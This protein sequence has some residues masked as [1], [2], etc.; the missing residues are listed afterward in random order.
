[1]VEWDWALRRASD[2]KWHGLLQESRSVHTCMWWMYNW[3]TD[4]GELEEGEWSSM[5][6]KSPMK[7]FSPVFLISGHKRHTLSSSTYLIH[8]YHVFSCLFLLML[9]INLPSCILN[10]FF[11]TQ[12]HPPV[13]ICQSSSLDSSFNMIIMVSIFTSN[14]DKITI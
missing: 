9:T 7:L 4:D 5:Q 12:Y 2:W 10:S 11:I 13:F 6:T 8:V 14:W 3:N 1:M